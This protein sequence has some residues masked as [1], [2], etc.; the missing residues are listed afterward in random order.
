M[1]FYC[2]EWRLMKQKSWSGFKYIFYIY[3]KV[4]YGRT[5]TVVSLLSHVLDRPVQDG[6]PLQDTASYF[7]IYTASN[8]EAP[9]GSLHAC[10]HARSLLGCLVVEYSNPCW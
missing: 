6:T 7:D 5:G 10:V 9:T 3:L 4:M 2:S 1:S 8:V